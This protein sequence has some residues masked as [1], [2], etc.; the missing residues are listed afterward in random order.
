LNILENIQ[1]AFSSLK[2]GKMRAFLTMLGII[3]GIGSVIAIVAMGSSLKA[4]FAT[5]MTEMGMNNIEV[6]LQPSGNSTTYWLGDSDLISME[7]IEEMQNRFSDRVEAVSI[8][9]TIGSGQ[10]KEGRKYANTHIR[11]V[12]DGYK[13]SGNVTMVDGRFIT[14]RDVQGGKNVAVISDFAA[15]KLF[16]NQN[17]LGLEVKLYQDAAIYTFTV[18][19]V[20]QHTMSG[21]GGAQ[22][23]SQDDIS[24]DLYIPLTTSYYIEGWFPAGYSWFSVVAKAGVDAKLLADDITA[25]LNRFYENNLNWNVYAYA[26]EM[27]LDQMNAILSGVALFI[28]AVAAISLIV[29]G[30][31]VMN[32]ML[33]SV[34]E[35]TREI[36]TRK[37]LGAR[38]SAIRIQFIVEA[39][40]ICLIGGVLGILLGVALGALG[41]S[42]VIQTMGEGVLQNAFD[43][44]VSA[45]LV[46]VAF[47][48]A[49]GVFFGFYPANKA[50]KLDPI[51]A[52]RYE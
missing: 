15:Q 43:I 20:Y 16:G 18:V 19:G 49:I 9:N 47:S 35:R 48:M 31:G 10:M 22:V 44:P 3:I 36:G 40:I 42:I 45:V 52:L 14:A 51:D 32:I 24:T 12:T 38:N 2:A 46:A 28:G 25:Y 23:T 21:F 29:G 30:I 26:M 4:S 37:A 50:A 6:G 5:T 17:P 33:V 13:V 1:L 27:Y 8:S 34:T 11:G 7:M 41:S 39:I